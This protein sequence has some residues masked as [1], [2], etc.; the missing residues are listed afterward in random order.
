MPL[1]RGKLSKFKPKKENVKYQFRSTS[2]HVQP[3]VI[4][5]RTIAVCYIK[6]FNIVF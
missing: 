4:K 2:V 3:Q 6:E 5:P 1:Y